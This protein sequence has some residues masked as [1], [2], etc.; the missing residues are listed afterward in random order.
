MAHFLFFPGNLR[1]L[2]AP[3]SRLRFVVRILEYTS[4]EIGPIYLFSHL[5]SEMYFAISVLH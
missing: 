4:L 5:G 2:A 3:A 1:A